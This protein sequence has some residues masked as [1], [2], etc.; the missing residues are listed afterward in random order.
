[1][2]REHMSCSWLATGMCIFVESL[3]IS[4]MSTS[5]AL[6]MERRGQRR[7]AFMSIGCTNYALRGGEGVCECGRH[8]HVTYHNTHDESTAAAQTHPFCVLPELPSGEKEEEAF[9]KRQR[10]DSSAE[11]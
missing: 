7:N 4:G 2:S 1:M 5:C 11:V 6:S 8:G 9:Q 3:I 10:M